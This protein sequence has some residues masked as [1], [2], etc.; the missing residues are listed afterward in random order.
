MR[1]FSSIERVGTEKNEEKENY[2][3]E[4]PDLSK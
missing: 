4:L 1:F 3:N 2:Q